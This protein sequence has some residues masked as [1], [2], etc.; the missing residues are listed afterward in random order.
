MRADKFV[1][2]HINSIERVSKLGKAK[3]L[4]RKHA[5]EEET[6]FNKKQSGKQRKTM[7]TDNDYLKKTRQKRKYRMI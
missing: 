7:Q 3:G 1:V 5:V 4:K 6:C 2:K